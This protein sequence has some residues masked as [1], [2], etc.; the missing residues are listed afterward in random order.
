MIGIQDISSIG[1]STITNTQLGQSITNKIAGLASTS[2]GPLSFFAGKAP[3]KISDIKSI[4][5]LANIDAITQLML[6]LIGFLFLIIIWW[7]HNK[8]N[9][10]S[11][12]CT[13]LETV[14]SKFPRISNINVTNPKYQKRLRDYYIK[15]AYNCCAGGNLKNDFV[16]LCALKNCIK[17]GARCL[18]FEIYSVDNLPVI[19]TSSISDF[20]VKESYNS[21]PFAQAMEV[22][23]IYA[24]SFEVNS[25]SVVKPDNILKVFAKLQ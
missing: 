9:L 17:Q 22:I 10:N 25:T 15:T 19:A 14:Y 6:L 12:N 18:D 23:A 11:Q 2:R 1:A 4:G 8:L 16:N 5:D 13:Q 20:S 3:T 21:V 7:L 24:F